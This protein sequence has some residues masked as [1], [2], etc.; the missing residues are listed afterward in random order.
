MCKH[1]F[2]DP[3]K[4]CPHPHYGK[5]DYCIF[6]HGN[7][8]K[9][10]QVFSPALEAFLTSAEEDPGVQVF[11]MEGFIFPEIHF[12]NRG[13]K[14][15]VD[16]KAAQF[17]DTAYFWKAQFSGNADFRTAQ[18]SGNAYFRATQFSGNADFREAQFS[19]NADFWA[20][21]VSGNA[22]FREAQFSGNADFR[23]AQVSG[24]AV[25][26]ATQFSGNA[27]FRAT[28]F[29]GNADFRSTQF[30]ERSDFKYAVFHDEANFTEAR[31]AF[32]KSLESTGIIF[33]GA[34]L[35]AAHL[36]GID[37]LE[38]YQFNDA[39]LLGVSLAGKSI[40]RCDFTGAVLKN[41]HT[42]GW[43][44]DEETNT[45]TR[46]IYTDYR[47]ESVTD[48]GGSTYK[49]YSPVE[50]SRVPADGEFGGHDNPHFT[51]E[52]YFYR[53]H[54]W[55]TSLNLPYLHRQ[56]FLEYLSFFEHFAKIKNDLDVTVY[57]YPE[58]K[59]VRL[60][61]EVED[62]TLQPQ[63]EELLREYVNYIFKPLE[64][65]ETEVVFRNPQLEESQKTELITDLKHSLGIVQH[66]MGFKFKQLSGLERKQTAQGL[67]QLTS[68][69]LKGID[70]LL[71]EQE[72]LRHL[73][74]L[75]ITTFNA[76][77]IEVAATASARA[78]GIN[79]TEAGFTIDRFT[80]V[81]DEI[82]GEIEEK[83]LA[84]FQS[85]L[86]RIK[87]S[88][89]ADKIEEAKGRWETTWNW[90]KEMTSELSKYERIVQFA[91]MVSIAL[92]G[93]DLGLVP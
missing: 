65:I 64:S 17:S 93:G 45:L 7:V 81:L 53:P 42:D 79:K 43:R 29:S 12:I 47:V 50:E 69:E 46:F 19:G 16:F 89:E 41:I 59:K 73:V 76:R 52:T 54:L 14:K 66:K 27:D 91:K 26:R 33:E 44:L 11:D 82:K 62:E 86:E 61:L 2:S 75:S 87:V 57:K 21:Q 23:E 78:E 90:I 58:G 37:T 5:S 32:Q 80:D 1:Q 34:V 6:H 51:L 3:E 24:N 31:F 36:W 55:N 40:C 48:E 38:G 84:C 13:F 18:F 49:I 35:E 8:E 83:W 56:A 92:D 68:P 22:N 4:K 30:I 15:S 25:F 85:E 67:L 9:K 63:V 70:E 77:Q 72:I 10:K 74:Q 20:T 28:Q 60:S 39:F 71:A 88:L